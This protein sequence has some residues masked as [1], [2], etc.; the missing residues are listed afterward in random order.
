MGRILQK[1][2]G[3]DLRSIGR[4]WGICIHG[5]LPFT[6][7][8]EWNEHI[9][10]DIQIFLS[11]LDYTHN[12]NYWLKPEYLSIFV[13]NPWFNHHIYH[14]I[15][16]L[17]RQEGKAFSSGRFLPRNY[18]PGHPYLCIVKKVLEFGASKQAV[19]GYLFS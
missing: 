3:G 12:Y 13:I 17:Q 6:L 14:A 2:K 10:D 16:I 19:S 11:F 4:V 15:L 1:L 5:I 18:I 8:T 7:F 9:S